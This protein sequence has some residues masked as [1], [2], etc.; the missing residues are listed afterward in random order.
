MRGRELGT[1]LLGF[2]F[3]TAPFA[4]GDDVSAPLVITGGTL[5]D[6]TG[7]EPLADSVIVIRNGKVVTVATAGAG[8]APVDARRLDAHGK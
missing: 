2:S 6:G 5:V 8:G 4:V 1:I 7:R 3:L